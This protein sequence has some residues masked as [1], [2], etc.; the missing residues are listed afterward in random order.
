MQRAAEVGPTDAT[1]RVGKGGGEGSGRYKSS[2]GR[3]RAPEA[4]KK[5]VMAVPRRGRRKRNRDGHPAVRTA[6]RKSGRGKIS[7]D[8]RPGDADGETKTGTRVRVRGTVK[9]KPG[10]TFMGRGQRKESGTDVRVARTAKRKRGRASS[11]ADRQKRIG[12]NVRATRTAKKKP[13]R[14]LVGR[15]RPSGSQYRDQRN[16]YLNR[17]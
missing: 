7:R 11:G 14:V 4:Y 3:P 17:G 10:W 12:M 2:N 5:V 9:T 1:T 6:K 16:S 15:G 8:G 13:E